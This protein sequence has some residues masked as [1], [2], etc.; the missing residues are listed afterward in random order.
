MQFNY[1][2]NN[3]NIEMHLAHFLALNS[4]FNESILNSTL[5]SKGV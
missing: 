3:F 2:R 5:E 4:N 1:N